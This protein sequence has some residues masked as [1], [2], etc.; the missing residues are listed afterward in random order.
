MTYVAPGKSPG[1]G[2]ENCRSLFLEFCGSCLGA[3]A[4]S[5]CRLTSVDGGAYAIEGRACARGVDVELGLQRCQRGAESDL[6]AAHR[7]VDR[8]QK[9]AMDGEP[10]MPGGDMDGR[11]RA[12]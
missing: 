2:K 12:R 7:V 6:D 4:N 10:N 5:D 11:R 1:Q 9:R 3:V 8:S